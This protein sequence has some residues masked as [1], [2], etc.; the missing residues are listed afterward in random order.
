MKIV[1]LGGGQVGGTLATLLD[2]ET[3]HIVVVDEQKSLL[4]G[5]ESR[6]EG[7]KTIQGNASSPKILRDADTEAADMLIAVT[8]NDEVNIVASQ[9]ASEVFNTQV[10][11][12]RVRNSQYAQEQKFAQKYLRNVRIINPETAVTTQFEQLLLYQDTLQVLY[13]ANRTVACVSFK[14]VWG[15]EPTQLLTSKFDSFRPVPSARMVAAYRD[16]EPITGKDQIFP[17]DEV[18]IT[19][20]ARDLTALLQKCTGQR[21]PPRKVCIAG[22]GHIGRSLASKLKNSHSI[23]I[24]EQDPEVANESSFELDGLIHCGDATD[25]KMLHECEIR[26]TDVFCAVTN[27]DEINIMSCLLAHK[28]GAKRTVALVAHDSYLGLIDNTKIDAVVSP[29]R[30]TV[31]SLLAHLREQNVQSAHRLRIGDGEIL[32]VQLSGEGEQ[33]K[34][35]GKTFSQVRLPGN[36]KIVSVVREDR[37]LDLDEEITFADQDRVVLFV[38][39]KEDVPAVLKTFRA[40]QFFFL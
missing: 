40:S 6:L 34:V 7:L 21:D 3:N 24:L 20:P 13:F 16:G 37:V 18:F 15:Y 1:I 19:V 30:S 14:A 8:G 27:N 2:D 9:V 17:T 12:A 25:P 10:I 38:P 31:S 35:I 39:E 32:E 22:A 4:E 33:N 29:Q 5:L 23:R 36:A 28:L 26:D 11:V